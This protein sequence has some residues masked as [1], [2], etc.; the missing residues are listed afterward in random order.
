[1]LTLS[2]NNLKRLFKCLS[3]LHLKFIVALAG[4]VSR[5]VCMDSALFT[6]KCVPD[7]HSFPISV[8]GPFSLIGGAAGSPGEPWRGAAR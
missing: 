6:G 7:A 1:M 4:K 2:V 5:V 3:S 8:P